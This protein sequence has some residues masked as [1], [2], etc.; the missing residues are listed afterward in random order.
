MMGFCF[1][2]TIALFGV[3]AWILVSAA[4]ATENK[5]CHFLCG[6]FA[7]FI[8]PF[9][10]IL[11]GVIF[12]NSDSETLTNLILLGSFGFHIALSAY[13]VKLWPAAINA[14]IASAVMSGYILLVTAFASAQAIKGDWL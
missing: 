3:W 5:D 9:G 1:P 10:L 12:A 6:C 14:I 4:K 7:T 11:C 2:L 13:L 8:T